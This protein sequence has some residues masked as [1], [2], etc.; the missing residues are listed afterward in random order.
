MNNRRDWVDSAAGIE[1]LIVGFYDKLF[2]S[3]LPSGEDIQEILCLDLQRLFSDFWWGSSEK[4]KRIHWLAWKKMCSPKNVVRYFPSSSFLN[5]NIGNEPSFVW[6]SIFWGRE[7]LKKGVRWR[8]GNG[9]SVSIYDDQWLPRASTFRVLSPRYLPEGVS[10]AGLI[11]D[12]GRWSEEIINRYFFPEE[13]NAILGIPLS[14]F[15]SC[16][17]VQWHYDKWAFFRLGVLTS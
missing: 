2:S 16:N 13:A 7:V 15:P 4:G 14:R 17:D 12:N 6:R 8:I 11:G 5:C 1:E 9:Y 3:T 10:V